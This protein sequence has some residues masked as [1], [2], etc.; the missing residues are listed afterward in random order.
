[1]DINT[2]RQNQALAILTIGTA[3]LGAGLFE[4]DFSAQGALSNLW[5]YIFIAGSFPF[6]A[7]LATMKLILLGIAVGHYFA[8]LRHVMRIMRQP[9]YVTRR[10]LANGPLFHFGAEMWFVVIIFALD[11]VKNSLSV[12]H[13]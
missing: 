5:E 9:S 11:V 13:P 3:V 8:M 10:Q 1:M 6:D 2:N 4:V 12:N 7:Y